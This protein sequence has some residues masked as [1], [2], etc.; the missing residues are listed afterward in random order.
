MA[1]I[2]IIGGGVAGLSAGIYAQLSGHHATICERQMTTGGNL[3]GWQRGEYHI[4]N[5]IHWLTGTN[6]NTALYKIWCNLG[7]LGNVEIYQPDSLYTYEGD[8]TQLSLYNNLDKI[9]E[10]L[11]RISPED[12]KEIKEFICAV[13]G[14]QKFNFIAGNRIEMLLCGAQIAPRLYKYF[15]LSTGELA[16][17]FKNKNIQGFLT[18]MLGKDF[19][20]LAL[21]VVFA[22]FCSGN[23]GIPAGSSLAMAK[24]MTQRFL[25]IGGNLL[26]GK[27]AINIIEGE[28]GAQIVEFSDATML[29]ADY[30]VIT[31]E[32]NIAFEKLLKKSVPNT[33]RKYYRNPKMARF[34]SMHCAFAC[35]ANILPFHGDYIFKLPKPQQ[36]A[37]KTENLIIREFSH[38]TSFAPK[39]ETVIQSLT[40]C[41][42]ATSKEWIEL[43]KNTIKYRARKTDFARIVQAAIV[44]KFP[45]LDGKLHLVDVWTP[46]TYHRYTNTEI[47]SYMAFLF[48]PKMLPHRLTN[49]VKGLSRVIL[50]SQWLQVPGGLPIAAQVGKD[51]I[52]R[53]NKV[54]KRKKIG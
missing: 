4:D 38:E 39:G 42:E 32:L 29:T 17:R 50:A 45:Q 13:K 23:G 14:V 40:F 16:M 30:V 9:E 8:E 11:L 49:S 37:L 10:E 51:A 44:E 3:T 53:I 35:K 43:R 46:A 47:G 7:A 26:L 12:K 20:A 21:L 2:L 31:T 27:E 22:T 25:E 48:P 36:Q 52:A 18:A 34:S 24:R 28:T 15:R 6:T 33:I 5:C 19:N 54:E 41:D 1:E